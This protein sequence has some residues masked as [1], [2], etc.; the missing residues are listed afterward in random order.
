MRV[1]V[2]WWDPRDLHSLYYSHFGPVGMWINLVRKIY[3]VSRCHPVKILTFQS[4]SRRLLWPTP[5]DLHLFC[6]PHLRPVGTWI[7]LVCR[8]HCVSHCQCCEDRPLPFGTYPGACCRQCLTICILFLT[9]IP[10]R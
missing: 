8:I 7:N 5:H 1:S 2:L 6:Y 10:D 9:L 4:L 3:C